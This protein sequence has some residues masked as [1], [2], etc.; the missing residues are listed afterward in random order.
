MNRFPSLLTIKRLEEYELNFNDWQDD[1]S[2][3]PVSPDEKRIIE[4]LTFPYTKHEPDVSPDELTRLDALADS[5]EVKRLVKM[6]VLEAVEQAG[7]SPKKLSTRFV[8]TWREKHDKDGK[9]IWLRRSRLVAREF[10][11]LQPDRD[12][13]F[14]PAS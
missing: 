10:A 2:G 3:D 9:P 12:A 14:S 13:L 7:E 1:D 5:M 11:W 6:H 8:R 4:H